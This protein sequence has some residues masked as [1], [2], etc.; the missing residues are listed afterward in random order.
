MSWPEAFERQGALTMSTIAPTQ[1][2]EPPN[3]SEWV[4]SPLYHGFA[5]ADFACHCR[6]RKS[7]TD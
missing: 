4:P 5:R 1:P 2:V 3:L 6:A 7:G